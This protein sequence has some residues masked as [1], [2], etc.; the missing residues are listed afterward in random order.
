LGGDDRQS[1]GVSDLALKTLAS[2]NA[3]AGLTPRN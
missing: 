1:A 2:G 3:L